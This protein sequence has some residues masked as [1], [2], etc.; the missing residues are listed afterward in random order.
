MNFIKTII[1][2]ESFRQVTTMGNKYIV[3]VGANALEDGNTECYQCMVDSNP[4]IEA[5]EAEL[6]QWKSH[7][8]LRATTISRQARMKEI[9]AEL[10]ATDYLA[11]KAYE[12]EDM[13]EH[14]G[15]KEKRAA[16]RAEYRQLE[17]QESN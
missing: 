1:P 16:L 7:R 12:G 9:L 11:L 17:A 15:W 8:L 5:I 13:G 14:K 10:Q 6:E 3:H 2:T 4:D